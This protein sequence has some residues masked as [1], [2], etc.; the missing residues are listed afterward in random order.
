MP[1][2]TAACSECANVM[3]YI[4]RVDDR[5]CTPVCTC[6]GE[7]SLVILKAPGTVIRNFDAFRSTVDG[8]VIRGDRDLREHN[9]RNGVM[10]L[11]DRYTDGELASAGKKREVV[12]DK[13]ELA[14]DVYEAVKRV[15]AGY[16]PMTE[17]CDG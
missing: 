9:A 6:G 14:T 2:Y 17:V 11:H 12:V 13:T 5:L 7:T 8:S 3:T 4:A 16:K 15:E 10:N 1:L